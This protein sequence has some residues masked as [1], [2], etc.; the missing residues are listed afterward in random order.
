[1]A[2]GAVTAD[3]QQDCTALAELV[4]DLAQVGELWRSDPAP[5]VAVKGQH[6]VRLSLELRE[7]HDIAAA[8]GKREI[9]RSLTVPKRCHTKALACY[10]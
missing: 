5:V 4:G 10:Q 8:R 7:R 1:V 2:K 6:N 9:R 3:R